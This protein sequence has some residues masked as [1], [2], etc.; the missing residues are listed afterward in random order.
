MPLG[1]RRWF[2]SRHRLRSDESIDQTFRAHGQRLTQR[3][4]SSADGQLASI[5]EERE[6]DDD[7][8]R[9]SRRP[10]LFGGITVTTTTIIQRFDAISG[11][12]RG[13]PA[14]TLVTAASP[15]ATL[16]DTDSLGS[17]LSVDEEEDVVQH[18][19]SILELSVG[20]LIHSDSSL[21]SDEDEEQ[22]VEYENAQD[23][24]EAAA[25]AA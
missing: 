14:R 22:S 1:I 20:D 6:P 2:S 9:G 5:R 11:S 15:D 18:R 19:P 13:S 10:H 3:D 4:V 23:P 25:Y 8:E 12:P 16:N 17:T 7:S 24:E 21:G